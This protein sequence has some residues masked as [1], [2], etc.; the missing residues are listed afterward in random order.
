MLYTPLTKKALHIS[1]DAH[2]DQV[3]KAGMPYVYHPFWVA[4]QMTTEA[5]T[6]V[7]PHSFSPQRRLPM[8]NGSC[9]DICGH[10]RSNREG[11]E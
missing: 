9:G 6:C 8:R 4:E 2:K 1:F 5:E 3:D 10:I 11:A 7:A